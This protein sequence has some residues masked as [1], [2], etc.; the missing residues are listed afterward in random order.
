MPPGLTA[1]LHGITYCPEAAIAAAAV[2]LGRTE[3]S[4][5]SCPASSEIG[6][7]N[8][9]AGPGTHPFHATGKIYLAGP[10]Q[11]AP[12]SLVVVTPALAGPYDYGTVVVRVALHIDPL[13]AHVIADSETVPEIIGG[14][15]LRLRSIQVN[16]NK[17]NF[18]INPTNCSAFT[19]ASQGV[20]DQ[21]TVANFS[22]PFQAVNC[23]TLPF[24]PRMSITQLGG[25]KATTAQQGPEPAI[26]LNTRPGDA[27]IKSLTV[28]LPKAF[29][30][31][32]RHLGNICDRTELASDQCAGRQ[33]IGEAIDRNPAARRAAQ[34]P[35]LCGLG[36]RRPAPPRLHPRRPGDA[37]ARGRILL[38]SRRPSED[39]RP[40]HPRCP[41][42]ALPLHPLR[43]LSRATSQTPRTSA[44]LRLS[45]RS[46]STPKTARS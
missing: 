40:G 12:L 34:R 32:Q 10:F 46:N 13:D 11:G 15:P 41:D 21:G 31:D 33:P 24:A 7:S 38:G 36:L 27:N 16:I 3:Q 35:R 23:E 9:A 29:E 5:P 6:T 19:V 26:E 22:S 25:H 17:P 39:R 1:N 44:A 37:D 18:M 14:I 45:P 30:I 4:N 42:R 20:G 8:V 43:R 28:T 2:T